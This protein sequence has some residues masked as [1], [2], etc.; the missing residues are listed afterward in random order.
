ML[1]IVHGL[2]GAVAGAHQRRHH[3]VLLEADERARVP[4]GDR[5]RARAVARTRHRRRE[6]VQVR[7]ADHPRHRPHRAYARVGEELK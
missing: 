2:D 7:R 4:P 3:V 1:T 5:G 6:Q